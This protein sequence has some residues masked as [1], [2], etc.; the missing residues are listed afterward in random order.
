MKGDE[1]VLLLC[2]DGLTSEALRKEAAGYLR[3]AKRAAL[4]VTADNIYKKENYHVPRGMKELEELDLR[5]DLFDLDE[6]PAR[7]LREYDA[8]E[9]IGGNP[10]YLMHAIRGSRAQ[11][12][13]RDIAAGGVLIGWSAAAFA[14][15]ASLELVHRYSPELN[16]V[17]LDDL[18][19]L[20]LA[21]VEVLPHYH[22]MLARY[23][24]FEERC[25]EYEKE[26]GVSVI[27]LDD[28]DGVLIDAG[29]MTVCRGEGSGFSDTEERK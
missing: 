29:R 12:V 16:D 4:V 6:Q 24:R 26:K 27:R 28:G 17:H 13:L 2:S 20:S 23:D 1:G 3:G 18:R 21:D 8:V 5:V 14:F 25:R 9:F 10:F 7:A 15:G 11:D 22:R 19:G